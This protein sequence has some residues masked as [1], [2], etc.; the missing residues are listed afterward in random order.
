MAYQFEY[1]KIYLLVPHTNFT[2]KGVSAESHVRHP[3]DLCR[4]LGPLRSPVPVP[5]SFCQGCENGVNVKDNNKYLTVLRRY[6]SRF[7]IWTIKKMGRLVS[8]TGALVVAGN[9]IFCGVLKI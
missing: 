3:I 1:L 7:W 4:Q 8:P 5:I 2:L 9:D 6:D